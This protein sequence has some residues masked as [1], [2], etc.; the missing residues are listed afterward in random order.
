MVKTVGRGAA[1]VVWDTDGSVTK[2]TVAV[3]SVIESTEETDSFRSSS[4]SD[5]HNPDFSESSSSSEEEEESPAS[6]DSSD[7]SEGTTSDLTVDPGSNVH[8][9]ATAS[10]NGLTL[11]FQDEIRENA[12]Q[13]TSFSRPRLDTENPQSL[14]EIGYWKLFFPVEEIDHILSCTN[15]K[16]PEKKKAVSQNERYKVFGILYAMTTANLPTRRSYWCV[17]DG[18]FPAPAF[19]RRFN[20][21]YHR[22]EDILRALVFSDSDGDDDQEQGREEADKWCLVRRFVDS[23]NTTW[24]EALR[25][26]YKITVD[27][28]M[29]AWYGKGDRPGGLPRVIKIKRKPKGVGCE[30]K[31][32]ADALSGIMIGIELNEGKEQNARKRWHSTHGATMSTTLR[33]TQPWHGS[34]RI[35]VGDSWFSSVKTAVQLRKRDLHFIGP[36]KTAHRTY[37]LAA[38]KRRCPADRGSWI[39]ATATDEDVDLIALGWQD[40]CVHTVVGTCG[41]TLE[42]S[43][44]KKR[45]LD[46]EGQVFFKYVDRAQMIE[47]YHAGAPALDVHNHLRQ[48]GLALEKVWGTHKWYHRIYASLFGIIETNAY[49]AFN[50]F[51]SQQQEVSHTEFKRKL[52]MQLITGV[53][54]STQ[55][56]RAR[57]RPDPGRRRT[58]R[59][60]DVDEEDDDDNRDHQLASLFS[61]TGKPH[62][63][64]KCVICKPTQRKASYYC[65]SCGPHFVLCGPTTGRLKAHQGKEHT[66]YEEQ[67]SS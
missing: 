14:D 45:R 52:A 39:A 11:H 25:P 12:Y 41:T 47:E 34:G 62:T 55:L 59:D 27:E 9:S 56:P 21:G 32:I 49:L 60:S 23:C 3:L 42:G 40:R 29:F 43:P 1:E 51:R 13:G 28:S 2:V 26:G 66:V 67:D 35:V 18:V 20:M 44:A 48:D 57:R 54:A 38:L 4:A 6:A 16:M 19:G 15:K 10:S 7:D 58:S 17:D 33:L 8:E 37:P 53:D 65:K 36:V 64:R 24:Q 22:F 5:D 50:Y 31:T 46:D 61:L 30:A 63:Q